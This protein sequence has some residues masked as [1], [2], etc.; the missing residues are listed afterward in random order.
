MLAFNPPRRAWQRRGT[1]VLALYGVDPTTPF[2]R[3]MWGSPWVSVP[4]LASL[5]PS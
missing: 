5:S 2:G 3:G 4:R 1:R